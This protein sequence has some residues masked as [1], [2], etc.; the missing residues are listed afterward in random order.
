MNTKTSKQELLDELYRP[1]QKC[2]ECP[3]GKTRN[4]KV[5]FGSGNPNAALMLIGEAPGKDEELQGKPFVGRSGKLLRKCLEEIKISENDSYITNIVKCR[6]PN[7]RVPTTKEALTCTKLLLLKQ[8]QIIQPQIICT[9][10]SYAFKYLMGKNVIF[11]ITKHHG[12]IFTTQ[13][14]KIFPI[15][16]PAFILRSQTKLPDLKKDLQKL[17]QLITDLQ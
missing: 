2:M 12:T 10:G 4:G 1:L 15:Y 14:I 13:N 16:H 5:V 3:L 17:K 6:P 9:V 11:K 8:I 7:N